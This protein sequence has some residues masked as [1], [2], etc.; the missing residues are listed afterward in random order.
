MGATIYAK[1]RIPTGVCKQY[2]GIEYYGWEK[3]V[4]QN[5]NW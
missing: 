3:N 2:G 1:Y 5:N 4:C